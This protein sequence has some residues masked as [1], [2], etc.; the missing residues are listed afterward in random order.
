[1]RDL[2]GEPTAQHDEAEAG[3]EEG[4]Y[5]E[6]LSETQNLNLNLLATHNEIVEELKVLGIPVPQ[7]DVEDIEQMSF[8]DIEA[9]ISKAT[10]LAPPTP[11]PEP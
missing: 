6:A 3:G 5:A 9:A 4:P 8:A 1:M 2:P 11:H 10:R 7:L